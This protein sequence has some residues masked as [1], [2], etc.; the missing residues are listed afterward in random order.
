[1]NENDAK[2]YEWIKGL[3]HPAPKLS[4]EQFKT[5]QDWAMDQLKTNITP[6]QFDILQKAH[7]IY[8]IFP[9]VM[10]TMANEIT[11]D[12]LEIQRKE[13][14]GTRCPCCVQYVKEYKRALS[15][16]MCRFLQSLVYQSQ[17]KKAES[18]S[19]WVHFKD[20]DYESHDY[21]YV[22]DWQLA[23][24]HPDMQGFY[25][26]TQLG[27]SFAF[28]KVAIPKHIYTYNGK[29]TGE[30][31]TELIKICDVEFKRFDLD[32]MLQGEIPQADTTQIQP[33]NN[34]KQQGLFD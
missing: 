1:M 24:R 12:K 11:K 34:D 26:P 18:G 33:S 3:T 8:S 9:S 17:L 32:D 5:L 10:I 14:G 28:G 27:I 16:N 6:Y 15:K 2:R 31:M 4:R 21:P 20:C 29:V 13:S 19:S 23:E 30:D 7:T 25:R 22:A